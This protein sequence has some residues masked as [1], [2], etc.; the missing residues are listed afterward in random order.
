MTVVLPVPA[1]AMMSSGPA[2]CVT[3]A[4]CAELRPSRIRSVPRA[5][6]VIRPPSAADLR[7]V[8]G[9]QLFQLGAGHDGH[10]SPDRALEG[11]E[12]GGGI[13][14]LLRR[15]PFERGPQEPRG[16]RVAGPEA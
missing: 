15:A 13:H 16:I 8:G 7:A 12:R 3:A 1:P 5:A 11:G 4:A 2:S 14:R 9:H 6:S 10:V